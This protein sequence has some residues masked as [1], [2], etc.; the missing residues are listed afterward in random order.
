MTKSEELAYYRSN[1][2]DKYVI[3]IMTSLEAI[4]RNLQRIQELK[5]NPNYKHCKR[6]NTFKPLTEFYKNPTKKQGVFDYCK[7][8]AKTGTKQRREYVKFNRER[9]RSIKDAVPT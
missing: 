9:E 1:I 5:N 6:C 4:E 3:E 2:I 7:E 8:C